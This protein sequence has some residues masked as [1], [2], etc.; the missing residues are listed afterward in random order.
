LLEIRFLSRF[1]PQ[2]PTPICAMFNIPKLPYITCV[3]WIHYDGKI[4]QCAA[5]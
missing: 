1:G 3:L 2:Y 5:V 4:I